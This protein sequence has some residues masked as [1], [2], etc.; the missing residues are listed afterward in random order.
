[1]TINKSNGF[2][3]NYLLQIC[4]SWKIEEKIHIDN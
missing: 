1:M 2:Q 4:P 3:L